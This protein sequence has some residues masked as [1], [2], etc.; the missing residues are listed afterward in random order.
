AA[1]Q[2]TG[3][4]LIIDGRLP[5]FRGHHESVKPVETVCTRGDLGTS[6]DPALG[7]LYGELG[8]EHEDFLALVA[9]L[10]ARHRRE[11]LDQGVPEETRISRPLPADHFIAPFLIP[12]DRLPGRETNRTVMRRIWQGNAEIRFLPS[13]LV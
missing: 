9:N 6:I 10:L 7:P 13:R 4:A 5:R 8:G 3:E 12:H 11:T 1:D 2:L